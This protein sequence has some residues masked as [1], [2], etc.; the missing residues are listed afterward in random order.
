MNC[1]NQAVD[2][3]MVVVRKN[4]GHMQIHQMPSEASMACFTLFMFSLLTW[5]CRLTIFGQHSCG[6]PYPSDPTVHLWPALAQHKKQ[7]CVCF[8]IME[9]FEYLM[10]SLPRLWGANNAYFLPWTD[11]LVTTVLFSYFNYLWCPSFTS[12]DMFLYGM[13]SRAKA[14]PL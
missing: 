8:H 6:G 12:G 9:G 11:K 14:Q 3:N 10:Q 5:L 7:V 4:P 13:L 2:H 1:C